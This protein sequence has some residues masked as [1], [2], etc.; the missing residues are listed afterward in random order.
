MKRIVKT[1]SN[2]PVSD[3]CEADIEPNDLQGICSKCKDFCMPQ[4]QITFKQAVEYSDKNPIAYLSVKKAGWLDIYHGIKELFI[5]RDISPNYRKITLTE[6]KSM[7]EDN[8]IQLYQASSWHDL[9][10][11]VI[12][13]LLRMVEMK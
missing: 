7:F 3:C 11:N 1:V 13:A 12:P 9:H 8:A 10:M 2:K 5:I 4:E 6:L